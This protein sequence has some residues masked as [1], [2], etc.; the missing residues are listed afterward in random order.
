MRFRS[1]ATSSAAAAK[2]RARR[3]EQWLQIAP[4]DEARLDEQLLGQARIAVPHGVR[5]TPRVTVV[6]PT[7][8]EASNLPHVLPRL[9]AVV[10]EVILVDGCSDDGTCE[11]ARRLRPDIK[12][13][14]QDGRG[15]G[16]A[17]SVGFAAATG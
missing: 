6:I 7:L 9:G 16:N 4:A 12:T 17:L 8:N 11:V 15:K 10:D 13:L 5:R 3:R 1:R 2:R 14:A